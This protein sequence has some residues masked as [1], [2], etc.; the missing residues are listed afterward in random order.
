MCTNQENTAHMTLQEAHH[1]F[2]DLRT[3]T[4][5]KSEIKVFDK[6]IYL[7]SELKNRSF[8]KE[9]LQSIETILDS[10]N[11][12][13][14]K[15]KSI[16]FFKKALNKFETFLKDTFSLTSKDHYTKLGAGLGMSFGILFGV[17]FLASFER[18]LGISLGLIGGMIIGSA[19]G[20]SMDAKALSESRVL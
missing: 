12:K 15:E 5:K 14:S 9:E 4:T 10:F 2:E 6:Y 8:T 20:R 7:L 19:I 1:F 3:E 17:V 13:S 11:L 16:R 18:S